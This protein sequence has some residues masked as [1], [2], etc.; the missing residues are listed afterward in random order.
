M[1]GSNREGD[2]TIAP[3]AAGIPNSHVKTSAYSTR[4]DRISA[5]YAPGVLCQLMVPVASQPARLA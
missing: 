1:G 2:F 4:P 3:R 5:G